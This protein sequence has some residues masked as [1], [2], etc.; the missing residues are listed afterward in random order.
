MGLRFAKRC[1][2]RVIER[3]IMLPPRSLNIEMLKLSSRGQ[4]NIGVPQSIRHEVIDR[5]GEEVFTQ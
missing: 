4:N 5:H 2:G 3:D 1:D